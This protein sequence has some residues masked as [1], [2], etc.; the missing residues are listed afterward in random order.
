MQAE[1][2]LMSPDTTTYEGQC[3][4]GAVRIEVKGEPE[5]AGYCHCKNCRS[6]SAGP[7]N[8]FTL[9]KPE[10]VRVTKG[11]DQIGEYRHSEQSWRQWCKVCGG[12]LLTPDPSWVWS[13]STPRRS[14]RSGRGD[15]RL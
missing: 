3:F 15:R 13:M 8:A 5:A 6:W 10:A 14:P 4:C 11:E 2:D 7:V 9:W 1:G 12:H